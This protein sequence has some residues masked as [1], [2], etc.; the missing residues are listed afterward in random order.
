MSRSTP[1]KLIRPRT[2][3]TFRFESAARAMQWW[4]SDEY[5]EATGLRQAST[6]TN[7]I[8]VEGVA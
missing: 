2:G 4:A 5:R 7:M 8:V 3:F 6:E 1:V